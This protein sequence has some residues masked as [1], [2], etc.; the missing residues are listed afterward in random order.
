M[1]NNMTHNPENHEEN[2]FSLSY[3][4]RGGADP[5]GKPRVFFTCHPEDHAVWFEKIAEILHTYQNCAIYYETPGQEM[6]WESLETYLSEMQ[7]VVVPVTTKLLTKSNRAMESVIPFAV[8]KHIPVLPL[9]MESGLTELFKIKFG[10]VQYLDPYSRDRTEIPF[11]Q[12]IEK[13]LQGVLVGDQLAERVRDAFA[14][15]IFLSYRKKDRAFAQK[16]MRRLHQNE[17]FRD[18]AIWY[19]EYLVP[20]ENF[21]DAI[22]AALEKGRLFTLVVTPSLLEQG[23]YVMR[24][25]YPEAKKAEKTILA[26]EMA[27]TDREAL[28]ALFEGIPEP[29]DSENQ[30]A[31]EEA[32]EECLHHIAF[33]ETKEDQVH[34]FLIGLAYLDGIDVEV[35]NEKAVSLITGAAEA[36]IAEAIEKLVSMYHDGKGVARDYHKSV[37]WQQKLVELY[38]EAWKQT[39]DQRQQNNLVSALFS[40][41]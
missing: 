25:E 2:Q 36:G 11:A 1:E 9:M 3:R 26:A 12:K 7:L 39:G 34:N 5:H 32:L 19:D 4:T 30:E 31:W 17:R 37:E 28:A 40:Q 41:L 21:S 29:V 14:A 27:K 38:R 6:P 33:T 13:Y 16:L 15:Y 22:R 8:E 20:G 23:N 35:D 10:D 24:Y 18:I